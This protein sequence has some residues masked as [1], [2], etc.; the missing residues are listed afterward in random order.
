MTDLDDARRFL[1]SR[2]E[3]DFVRLYRAHNPALLLLATRLTGSRSDAEDVVQETWMRA[4]AALPRFRG[5][6]SLRTWLCGFVA[7]CSREL[8]RRRTEPA[9]AE[10]SVTTTP[11]IDLQRAIDALPDGA[12]EV[13]VLHDVHGY[14]HEEVGA[15]LGIEPGTSKSQLHRARKAIRAHMTG[16]EDE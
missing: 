10:E 16:V 6:S 14:T 4:V 11:E 9:I 7:N 8:R 5:E 15:L 3:R 13:L 12:R 1:Q 2:G